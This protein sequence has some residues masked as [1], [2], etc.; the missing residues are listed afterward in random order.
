MLK[1]KGLNIQT[2][3]S[4][5]KIIKNINLNLEKGKIYALIGRNGSGKTTLA[6][7]IMGNPKYKITKGKILLDG[8]DITK[9]STDKKAK[10]G[11]F[12]SFQFPTEIS[13]V[14]V[15]DFLRTSFNV[16]GK[17]KVSFLDFQNMLIKNAR[18]LGLNESFLSRYLNEGFSG[19]EKKKTE[20]LQMLILDPKFV[21][22]DEI[23]SGLDDESLKRV[24]KTING[25]MNKDKCLLIITHHKKI[26][27]NLEINKTFKIHNGEI[28]LGKK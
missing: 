23:D 7:A 22:L 13:G 20:I 12:L 1:I 11:I 24:S 9:I 26:L 5:K 14:T 17:K 6:N 18:L 19:G 4:G 16:L 27:D 21:I 2:T 28:S 8:K 15:S 25:F 3:D 10:K